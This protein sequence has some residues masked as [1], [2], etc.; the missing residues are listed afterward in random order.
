MPIRF[1]AMALTSKAQM[2]AVAAATVPPNS[3]SATPKSTIVVSAPATAFGSRTAVSSDIRS[4]RGATRFHAS[5]SSTLPHIAT[6]IS[7]GCS[8]FVVK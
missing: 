6:F 7:I 8:A 1:T 3:S 2:T 5:A 4:S